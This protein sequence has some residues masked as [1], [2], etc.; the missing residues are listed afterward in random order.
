[1]TFNAATSAMTVGLF[2]ALG[3]AADFHHETGVISNIQVMINYDVEPVPTEFESVYNEN[4]IEAE[5]MSADIPQSV[6]GEKIIT[7]SKA[8]E[9]VSQLSRDDQVTRYSVREI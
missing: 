8:F 3:E 6:S 5:F 1:M 7:T 9:I 2:N 4:F